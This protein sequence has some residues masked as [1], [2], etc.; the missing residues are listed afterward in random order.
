MSGIS[1][2]R[3]LPPLCLLHFPPRI[4]QHNDQRGGGG[5]RMQWET[6]GDGY[7]PKGESRLLPP[8]LSRGKFTKYEGE[9]VGGETV[10]SP[11]PKSSVLLSIHEK[12]L[13]SSLHAI[14]K[15]RRFLN[16]G[17]LRFKL[18][19]P[20]LLKKTLALSTHNSPLLYFIS[21]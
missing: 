3:Q 6:V 4:I 18:Q 9:N 7:C 14:S 13:Q 20:C 10:L 17:I 1:A 15:T 21:P 19:K 11:H 16:E 5:E 8:Q 2:K 12:P